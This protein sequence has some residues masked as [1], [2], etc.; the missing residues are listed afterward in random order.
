MHG[1]VARGE[2]GPFSDID[3]LGVTNRKKKPADF[4]YFDGDIYVGI[5]FLAVSELEREFTDPKAFYWARG[6]AK[7]TRILY[8]PNGVLRRIMLRW[9]KT[10]PSHQILENLSGTRIT[11]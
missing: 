10:K 11:T 8:D 4:S 1:S 9:K 3:M 2:P 5:G 6:S 7:T